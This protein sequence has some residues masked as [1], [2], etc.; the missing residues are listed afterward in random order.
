MATKGVPPASLS[1]RGGPNLLIEADHSCCQGLL[2]VSPFTFLSPIKRSKP[3][4][5]SCP[6]AERRLLPSGGVGRGR[7]DEQLTSR[8]D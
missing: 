8:R 7:C 3:S 5:S 1:N 2:S 4:P 6:H